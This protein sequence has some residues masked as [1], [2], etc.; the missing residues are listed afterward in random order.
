MATERVIEVRAGEGARVELGTQ[1]L[2]YKLRGADTDGQFALLEQLA[3]PGWKLLRFHVHRTFDEG[4]YVLEGEFA[5][6]V[7]ARSIL[8]GPGTLV[9]V[10]RGTPHRYANAGDTQARLLMTISPAG[11]EGMFEEVAQGGIDTLERW[12]SEWYEPAQESAE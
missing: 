10:P 11:F 5:F 4:F 8:A 3:A 9:L 6:Q 1:T 12:D 2:V 7:G